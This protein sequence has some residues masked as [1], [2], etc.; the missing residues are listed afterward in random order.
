MTA[1]KSLSHITILGLL[2]T[3][4]CPTFADQPSTVVVSPSKTVVAPFLGLGVQWDPFEYPP[5]PENWKLITRRMDYCRPGY[6]RVMMSLGHYFTGFDTAGRPRFVWES[7]DPGKRR[8]FDQILAI[9]DFAQ[10]RHIDVIL[11]EWSPPNG[12]GISGQTDPKWAEVIGDLLDYLRNRRGYTV[13]RYYNVINEPN[14]NWS[15]NKDFATW[16]VTVG[17]LH[18]ELVRRGLDKSVGIVGPDASVSSNW[19]ESLDWLDWSVRDVAADIGAWDLHWYAVDPEVPDDKLEQI[20]TH[21]RAVIDAGD[22]EGDARPRFLAESGIFT[23]RVNGDQQPR[24]KT[25]EYGVLMADY[26]AQVQRAGWQGALAWDLDDAMHAV[27]GNRMPDP[28][29]ALTLKVWGFWNTQGPLMGQP[30]DL[31]IR[32]WFYT[33]STMSRL[34]PKGSTIVSTSEPDLPRFRATAAT[35]R[36]G[37]H[38]SLSVM[39]VNDDDAPRVVTVKTDDGRRYCSASC[40]DYFDKDR[41]ADAGGFPAPA[42]T[43]VDPDLSAGVTVDLPGRGVVL[44]SVH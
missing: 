11:G 39:L 30:D 2:G 23:G 22:P 13:V 41:P 1:Q 12:L 34:F 37:R 40:Y 10:K 25:F 21:K 32:P 33:W 43:M 15:G 5:S 27:S 24:V 8:N 31:V 28:P 18:D 16:K 14:G 38:Q 17:N 19:K 9:L 3:L 26:V 7:A 44:M 35:V 4:T 20:L 29:D 42:S 6:L 36:S